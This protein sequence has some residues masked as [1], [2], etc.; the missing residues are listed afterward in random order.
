MAKEDYLFVGTDWFSIEDHQKRSIS[1][2][3]DG[4]DG[5]RLLNTSADDLC[6]YFQEKYGIDV[7][8]L[9]ESSI[10]VDQHEKQLDVSRDT[11]RYISDRS[12]PFYVAATE[13]EVTIPFTGDAD[14]F[15]IK[16]TTYTT[17]PPRAE[18][19]SNH[20]LV[21]IVG[22][23]LEAARVKETIA[24][25]LSDI[26]KY[27]DWLRQ[28]AEGFN[29]QIEK[30]ARDRIEFRRKKLLGD[31]NLVAALGFPLKERPGAAKT[32]VA[33][34]VKRKITPVMP[35]AS[36]APYRPE[37][38]LSNDD[39]LHI[40][41][42]INNMALVMERSPSA[43]VAMDEESLR[44]HFLVQLNGQY[45]GQ[46]T[47]ETFNYEGKTDILVRVDGKNIFIAECKFWNGPKKL[48]ETIDQ[49]L[50]Y[51]SWRDTKTSVIIFNRKK[52]FTKVLE[53]IPETV[54]AHPNFKR[55]LKR[56]GETQFGFVFAH[57]DD[58]NR[59]IILTILAFDVPQT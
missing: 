4:L 24:S 7:P 17:S 44:S 19:R 59:E 34:N 38:I 54:K 58:T 52:N 48:A 50:G 47:G 30:I 18:V 22:T 3:V 37:P 14:A 40:L 57:R 27:L 51:T 23:N 36:T 12:R 11:N 49:L 29:G 32:F 28:N 41:S 39:Y 9:D 55:E 53:S 35:S 42:V 1:S 2:E 56:E 31:R 46:A 33:P 16:P 15:K 26:N 43:F 21:R 20:V 13:I 25:T 6:A 5:D 8:V 10:V 45:E